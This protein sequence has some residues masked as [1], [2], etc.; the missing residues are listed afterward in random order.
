[1]SEKLQERAQEIAQQW[2]SLSSADALDGS[3][4]VLEHTHPIL[5]A[6]AKVELEKLRDAVN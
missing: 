6:A 1:M 5:Y 2:L 3:M 4:M